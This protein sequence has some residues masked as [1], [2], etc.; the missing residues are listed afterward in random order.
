[1]DLRSRVV[2]FL[3]GGDSTAS[4][5]A[6]V[7]RRILDDGYEHLQE[8]LRKVKQGF[9]E[10][11]VSRRQLEQQVQRLRV[12]LSRMDEESHGALA[13]ACDALERSA[14]ERKR[15]LLIE[16]T[17]LEERAAQIVAEQYTF[18]LAE[19]DLSARVEAFRLRRETL[20][21]RCTPAEA[22]AHVTA[23]LSEVTPVVAD[24]SAT[25]GQIQ[26]RIDR[27]LARASAVAEL[28]EMSEPTPPAGEAD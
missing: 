4:G 17:G 20:A 18:V 1:M 15:T 2:L 24:L 19:Q 27:M 7:A 9:I 25:L 21:A 6:E 28:L 14:L 26:D 12:R 11:A 5:R 16:L 3:R 10:V 13:A 22:E 8:L 23:A